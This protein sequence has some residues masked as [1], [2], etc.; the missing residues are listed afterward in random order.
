MVPASMAAFPD[1][2]AWVLVT[3]PLSLRRPNVEWKVFAFCRSPVVGSNAFDPSSILKPSEVSLVFVLVPL[4]FTRIE[5]LM[6]T[7][8]PFATATEED[9]LLYAIVVFTRLTLLLV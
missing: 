7:D 9:P 3:P 2:S 6:V 1:S 5:F 8:P 4:F